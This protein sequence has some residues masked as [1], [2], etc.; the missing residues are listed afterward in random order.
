ML[1][2]IYNLRYKPEPTNGGRGVTQ[3]IDIQGLIK[4]ERFVWV[5]FI[6]VVSA[7]LVVV[8]HA[9]N[10]HTMPGEIPDAHWLFN[11]FIDTF[12]RCAVPM[13]LMISGYLLLSKKGS[14]KKGFYNRFL[15][16]GIPLFVWSIIY[17]YVRWWKPPGQI[18]DD[19]YSGFYNAFR[20]FL[21]G[22]G[23][24]LWFLYAIISLYLVAP[25]FHSYLKSASRESKTYFLLLCGFG[26]FLW[27]ILVIF[28]RKIFDVD[29]VHFDIYV[30]NSTI[31]YFIVGYF[32]GHMKI[33]TRTFL[34]CLVSFL[35]I[36]ITVTWV[37]FK[38]SYSSIFS[39]PTNLRVHLTYYFHMRVPMALLLFVVIKY[40]GETQFYRQSKLSAIISRLA[41]FSFGVYIVHILVKHTIEDG[42][43][44]FSFSIHMFDPW[45][46]LP[47]VSVTT[48]FLSV[49][50]VW[51]LRKIPLVRWILP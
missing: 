10:S 29:K 21:L 24:H 37:G 33:S 28:L 17:Y 1:E 39:P 13:F 43:L 51:L 12:C 32:L 45:F 3:P 30:M 47:L 19:K 14:L 22:N 16:I 15:K 35:L 49:L 23:E 2:S 9:G 38:F 27:P 36:A 34:W 20:N 6:R 25:I 5:D 11:N 4:F 48:F 8:A 44:G 7:F 42:I 31:G 50:I 18:V 26:C 46:S 40:I 41:G